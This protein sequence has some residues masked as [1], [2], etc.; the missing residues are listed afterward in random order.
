[1]A[2]S[3]TWKWFEKR[4]GETLKE[5]QSAHRMRAYRLYDSATARTFIPAQPADYFVGCGG[6]CFLLEVKTSEEHDSLS[7]NLAGLMSTHQAGELRLWERSGNPSLVVFYSKPARIVE[8]W[9]GNHV[10]E[11][12]A[13]GVR[14]N[15]EAAK[16]CSID[17]FPMHLYHA[18]IRRTG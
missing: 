4:V 2:K 15:R 3:K 14:L 5:L 8:I 6:R 17:E 12:R 16:T 7:G 13:Q 10:A 1:V 9:G 11:H 18:L